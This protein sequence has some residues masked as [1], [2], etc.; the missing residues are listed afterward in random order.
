[1]SHQFLR[2]N[3]AKAFDIHGAASDK[4]D[5]M[6]LQLRRRAARR[7]ISYPPYLFIPKD[8]GAAYRTEHQESESAHRSRRGVSPDHFLYFRYNLYRIYIQRQ[9]LDP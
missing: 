2:V 4:I 9:C 7:Y 5:D 6:P 8:R 3:F 1:M